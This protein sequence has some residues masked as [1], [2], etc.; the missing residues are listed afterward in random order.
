MA[1]PLK[2]IFAA[3]IAA[4]T[5][6]LSSGSGAMAE[7]GE[8][9]IIS[10]GGD[11]TEIVYALGYGDQ[12][13]ATDST[14]VH[15]PAA[16]E[17]PKVGYVR[18][19]AAESLL[20][21]RPSLLI[22]GGAAGPET[23]VEQLRSL[24]LNMLEM[25]TEYSIDAIR[26]KVEQVAGALDEADR[27]A[28]MI[29]QIDADWVEAREIISRIDARPTALFFASM[30]DGGPRAAGT[31]TAAHAVLEI[32]GVDNAFDDREGY[33]ALSTEAAVAAD[34]DLIFVM[35]HNMRALGGLDAVASDPALSLTKAG[36]NGRIIA[37]DSV[38]V[39]SFGP[40]FAEGMIDTARD[41]EDALETPVTQ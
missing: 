33:R 18:E 13:V 37:V 9:R 2:T 12:V 8:H 34:P 36:R 4:L 28:A 19:L 15:P 5:L 6:V 1:T 14:S 30:G 40:R 21:L 22:L 38:R 41:L 26:N 25:E 3:A 24:G 17:T 16:L 11:V 7:E 27:G 29:A 20:S 10:V 39:M 32:L 35:S 23:V 31:G